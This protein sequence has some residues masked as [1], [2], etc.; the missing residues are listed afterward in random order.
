MRLLDEDARAIARQ[1]ESGDGRCQQRRVI[2]RTV[3]GTGK[4]GFSGDGGPATA[5]ELDSPK[6]L[7]VDDAP[8][9]RPPLR[10]FGA[11]APASPNNWERGSL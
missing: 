8:G 3:A 2:I 6:G 4:P 10:A 11:P 5:A 9:D 7:A 1:I